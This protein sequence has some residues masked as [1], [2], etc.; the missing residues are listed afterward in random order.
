MFAYLRDC[1]ALGRVLRWLA[2]SGCPTIACVETADGKL[3][4]EVEG[5]TFRVERERLEMGRVAAECDLC[6]CHAPH[7]TTSAMLS[8]GRPVMMLPVF[9][10][11]GLMARAA[12]LLRG[13]GFRWVRRGRPK[14]NAA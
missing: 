13:R 1:P 2:G 14:L 9:L 4:A 8:A 7:G 12:D 11:Q 6:V 3:L 10:E 5:P